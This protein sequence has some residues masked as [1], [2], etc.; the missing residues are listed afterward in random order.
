M[1]GVRHMK[2][3]FFRVVSFSVYFSHSCIDRKSLSNK[4][5][6]SA[7]SNVSKAWPTIQMYGG[8][9]ETTPTLNPYHHWFHLPFASL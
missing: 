2:Y 4:C 9:E 6:Q 7:T 8:F 5:P 1:F 3:D